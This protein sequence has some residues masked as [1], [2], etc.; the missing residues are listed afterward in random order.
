LFFDG[1]QDAGSGGMMG[2]FGLPIFQ[3][4]EL[5]KLEARNWKETCELVISRQQAID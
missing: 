3:N 5:Y 2:G 1:L 4:S